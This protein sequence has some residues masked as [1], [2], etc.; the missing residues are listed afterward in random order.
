M[1]EKFAKFSIPSETNWM[2]VYNKIAICVSAIM[3]CRKFIV[4]QS[5]DI[6]YFKNSYNM[7]ERMKPAVSTV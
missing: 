2:F 5:Y 6:I 7:I 1:K 4:F 3:I